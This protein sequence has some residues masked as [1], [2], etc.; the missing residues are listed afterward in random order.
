MRKFCAVLLGL[1]LT[2]SPAVADIANRVVPAGG[3]LKASFYLAINPDCSLVAYPT[4]RLLTRPTNGTVSFRKGKAFPY[5]PAANPR[6]A[7]NRT[8]VPAI[9]T[10]YRPNR[11]FVG[12]DSFEVNAIFPVGAERTDT[13]NVTVK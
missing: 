4:V 5:F 10:E 7:C 6:S 1:A 8:R 9:L 3:A 13:F 12:V 11:G 2:C